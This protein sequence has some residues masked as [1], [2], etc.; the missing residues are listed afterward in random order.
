M[1]KIVADLKKIIKFKDTTDCGDVVLVVAKDPQL[2][3]YA[4]VTNI[5]RDKSK[6][7]EWWHVT[8]QFLT[9]PLQEVTWILRTEQMIGLEIFTMDGKE[10]F[11]KAIEIPGHRSAPPVAPGPQKKKTPVLTIVKK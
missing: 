1:E 9:V 2:L 4:V 8:M 6:R 7:D 10:R 11:V 5:E 3:A